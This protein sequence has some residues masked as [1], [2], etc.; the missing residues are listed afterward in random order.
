MKSFVFAATLIGIFFLC[1]CQSRKNIIETQ[2]VD[3]LLTNYQPSSIEKVTAGDLDF[4]QKR[5]DSS[6]KFSSAALQYAHKLV[7]NFH[8]YGDIRQ[9]Q[10]A[11]SIYTAINFIEKE[12]EAG[13]LRS[14]ATLNISK[15]RFKDA[16][17]FSR[18]AL[19]IGSDKYASSFIFFD[20][21][22]ESGDYAT[23]E[24]ILKQCKS[25]FQ[26]GYFFRAS[27]FWHWKGNFDSS[28]AYML[29]AAELGGKGVL[30]ETALTNAAD[31]YLH[32]GKL[33]EAYILFKKS[34]QTNSADYHSLQGLGKIVLLHDD[35]IAT[36]QKIFEFIATKTKMP[37]AL[38]YLSWVAEAAKDTILQRKYAQAFVATTNTIVYGNMYNKYLIEIY[39]DVLHNYNE[40]LT[41]AEREI[42]NRATP[43][44]YAWYVYC[45][46]LAGQKNKATQVYTNFVANKPLE[47]LDLFWIGKYMQAN[48]KAYNAVEFFKAAAK[49]K[50]DL[51][52]SKLKDLERTL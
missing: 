39:T 43:Q 22:F 21:L 49:N 2:F 47:A 13:V 17:D 11:D 41:I 16:L 31:L 44:T 7:Q 35:S 27:K 4:W 38:Y 18:K 42:A 52:P 30:K 14:L 3:S 9:L 36:A 12:N 8:L 34:L 10:K 51:S 1:S 26:Y 6:P 25:T 29:K 20:A 46:H 19:L 32:E 33:N 45:L 48:G 28:V 40:A 24:I 23:A 37:D 15:H 5:S 50:Y